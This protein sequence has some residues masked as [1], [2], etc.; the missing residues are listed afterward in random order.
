MNPPS[1]KW[2]C[3]FSDFK[4]LFTDHQNPQA[5]IF[6]INF[7]IQNGM[8]QRVNVD[9]HKEKRPQYQERH[10][11]VILQHNNAP[12][13]AARPVK[14]YLETLKWGVLRYPPYSRGV[15]LSDS[16]LFRSMAHGLAHQNFRSY[17]G[18]KKG[19]D[20]W[21]DSKDASFFRDGMRQLPERWKKVVASDG[22]YF[23]LQSVQQERV[24]GFSK[25]IRDF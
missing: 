7:R 17:E 24:L 6:K 11:K 22:Q 25:T 1:Y 13:H 2:K 23:E 5:Q 20:S 16:H 3:Q 4:F 21:F 19:I 12:L 9:A 14:T 10:D 18:V 8:H 15:A